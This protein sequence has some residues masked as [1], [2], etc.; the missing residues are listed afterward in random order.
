MEGGH[1][2]LPGFF[3]EHAR[4][5][6]DCCSYYALGYISVGCGRALLQPLPS[7]EGLC[8]PDILPS[9]SGNQRS[10]ILNHPR[11]SPLKGVAL[12]Q[13]SGCPTIGLGWGRQISFSLWSPC[14]P[15]CA[16]GT[17]P[18]ESTPQTCNLTPW[19]SFH[20][21]T[22][23]TGAYE[24]PIG[25]LTGRLKPEV[26]VGIGRIAPVALKAETLCKGS[27]HMAVRPCISVKI[28]PPF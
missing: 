15:M 13:S 10:R 20:S 22:I 4:L 21:A 1:G 7:L 6:P 24:S 26:P 28:C 14:T 25:K 11:I 3:H 12:E 8:C 23:G 27:R 2:S 16:M 9:Q 18:F 17:I 5:L 19:V